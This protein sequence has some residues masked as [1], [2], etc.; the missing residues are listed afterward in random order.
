MQ[1]H[2]THNVLVQKDTYKIIQDF[3]ISATWQDICKHDFEWLDSHWCLYLRLTP[4]EHLILNFK[5]LKYK[6]KGSLILN[7]DFCRMYMTQFFLKG[8]KNASFCFLNSKQRVS[9]QRVPLCKPRLENLWAA[10]ND[11]MVKIVLTVTVEI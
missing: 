11:N 8:W 3:V 6:R 5:I 1:Y 2:T 4:N 9:L 7:L 10:Y